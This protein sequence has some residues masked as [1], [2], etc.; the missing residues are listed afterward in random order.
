MSVSVTP[1]LCC[2]LSLLRV[3]LAAVLSAQHSTE[4][5]SQCSCQHKSYYQRCLPQVDVSYESMNSSYNC[6]LWPQA[7]RSQRVLAHKPTVLPT[8]TS[9]WDSYCGVILKIRPST[10]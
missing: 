3:V 10:L 4:Q 2:Q 7:H 5:S 9:S 1:F 6:P 8:P